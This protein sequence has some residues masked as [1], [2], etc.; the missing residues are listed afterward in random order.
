[1]RSLKGISAHRIQQPISK[2]R[3]LT[4]ITNFIPNH[5]SYDGKN[6]KIH[7]STCGVRCCAR[8]PHVLT[9][10][11]LRWRSKLLVARR[12]AGGTQRPESPCGR[13]CLAPVHCE[14]RLGQLTGWHVSVC[15]Q[16]VVAHSRLSEELALVPPDND[17][18]RPS[19]IHEAPHCMR[20][21]AVIEARA[22]V[23][24]DATRLA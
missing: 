6:N 16:G 23:I 21:D 24:F 10:A 17:V 3:I 22:I 8:T 20:G 2:L 14:R 15:A 7:G 4:Y 13:R 11:Q 18:W 12:Y 5:I 9:H 19:E 1:M